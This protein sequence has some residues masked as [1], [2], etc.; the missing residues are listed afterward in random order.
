MNNNQVVA[1]VGD[2]EIT[3]REVEEV[4]RHVDRKVAA[5]FA[6]PDGIRNW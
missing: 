4:L 5:Q 1:K 2:R 6:G 3:R